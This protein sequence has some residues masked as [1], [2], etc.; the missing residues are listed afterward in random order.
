MEPIRPCHATL[1]DLLDRVLDK[2]LVIQADLIISVAGVPLIGVNIRA[3]LAGIETMLEYGLMRDW[4]EGMRAGELGY[5]VSPGASRIIKN[6]APV[7][8]LS[9]Y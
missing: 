3:V 5:R 2:G 6:N 7:V 9:K 8:A 1:V 4:D